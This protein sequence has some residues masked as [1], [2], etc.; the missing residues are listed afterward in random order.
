MRRTLRTLQQAG[1]GEEIERSR[2]LIQI[3]AHVR[4]KSF[5]GQN[6]ARMAMK[7]H[8]QIEITRVTQDTDAA[9]EMLKPSACHNLSIVRL[10]CRRSK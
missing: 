4:G 10:L 3:A 7:K 2:E 6:R 9:Q 1:V 5:A 8:Q